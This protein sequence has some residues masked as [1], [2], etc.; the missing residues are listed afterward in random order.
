MT[1]INQKALALLDEVLEER[2]MGNARIMRRQITSHEALCRAIEQH[3]AFRQEVSDAVES[4]CNTVFVYE[5]YLD[6]RDMLRRRFIIAKP[7]PLVEALNEAGDTNP[8]S[9]DAFAIAVR[10][11]LAARGLK[12]VEVE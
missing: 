2:G 12:I 3:E 4:L 8:L 9:D 1:D 10:K 5:E 11:A 7:D 6:M